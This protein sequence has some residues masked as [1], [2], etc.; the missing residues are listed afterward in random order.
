MV[1]RRGMR[2]A[3]FRRGRPQGEAA[4]AFPAQQGLGGV[5]QRLFQI[6]VVIGAAALGVPCLRGLLR[7]AHTR[8]LICDRYLQ[9]KYILT[10]EISYAY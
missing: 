7:P 4:D 5:E 1:F 9:R 2:H 10:T 8:L 3:D 6:A